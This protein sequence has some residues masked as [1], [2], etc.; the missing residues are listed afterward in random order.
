M[1]VYSV[2]NPDEEAFLRK[3]CNELSNRELKSKKYRE[4]TQKMIETVTDPS[5]DGVGIAG[6]QVGVGKRLI[7]VCRL[8]KEGE[9]FVAYANPQIDST[10]GGIVDG[11]EGCL[12]IPGK[13]GEVPRYQGI[14]VSYTNPETLERDREVVTDYTARIFQHEIDHTNGILYTDRTD[15]IWDEQ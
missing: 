1:H 10:F 15:K 4:L 6:P 7:V 8:D 2:E 13:Y 14:I 12:S 9:P 5:Q 3:E 11:R